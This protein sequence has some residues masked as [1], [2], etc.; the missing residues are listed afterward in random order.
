M[1]R[2]KL[3]ALLGAAA[4]CAPVVGLLFLAAGRQKATPG[5]GQE[6]WIPRGPCLEVAAR[7]TEPYT[8]RYA[9]TGVRPLAGS[10]PNGPAFFRWDG[11]I[12]WDDFSRAEAHSTTAIFKLIGGRLSVRRS[13]PGWGSLRSNPAVAFRHAAMVEM[14]LMAA[15]MFEIPDVDFAVNYG[16]ANPCG[17]PALSYAPD[18]RCERGGFAVPSWAAFAEALG[19]RQM[20]VAE[21]C[22]DARHPTGGRRH[23]GV[24]R[25]AGPGQGGLSA[26]SGEE[27]SAGLARPGRQGEGCV[28]VGTA[29]SGKLNMSDPK[30]QNLLECSAPDAPP[31]AM[32]DLNDFDVIVDADASP[33]SPQFTRLALFNTPLLKQRPAAAADYYS[34]LLA[35]GT[36]ALY[37]EPDLSD[38]LPSLE[39]ALAWRLE[40]PGRGEEMVQSMRRFA[41]QHLSHV[42]VLR[43]TAAALVEVAGRLEWEVRQERGYEEIP[44]RR[45]C[46]ANPTFP[47]QFVRR[48]R[49]RDRERLRTWG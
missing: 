41:R 47:E 43:A 10:P 24:W 19:P 11:Q 33:W 35:N 21:R 1:H 46:R 40:A 32:E 27:A 5:E 44:F 7:T 42:G 30:V 16:D 37:F 12:S 23:R 39:A 14:L 18:A 15:H 20:G 29:S 25:G 9:L 49:S 34:H 13:G 4:T 17:V 36:H 38:L 22:L 45:C 2:R 8:G 28:A 48:V 31:I 6:G 3:L 26:S